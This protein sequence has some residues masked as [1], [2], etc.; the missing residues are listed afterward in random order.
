MHRLPPA[1]LL[2]LL[3][4]PALASLC[5][6]LSG[7]AVADSEA[8]AVVRQRLFVNDGDFEASLAIGATPVT[9]LTR[10]LALDGT[11]G[12]NVAETWSIQVRGTY[13]FSWHTRTADDASAAVTSSDPTVRFRQVDD[14]ED[15]WTLRWSAL[16]VGRWMPI[17][18]KVSLFSALPVHFGLY[19]AAGVGVGGLERDSLVIAD[20]HETTLRP[21]FF[22]ALGL[23]LYLTSLVSLNLEV[24]DRFFADSYRVEIDRL[25]EGDTGQD[26]ASP[27]LTHLVLVTLGVTFSF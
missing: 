22:G 23:R 18:G 2:A 24:G 27:G 7:T 6:L 19:L 9:F 14:Y 17:Y 25:S 10:H 15:L 13:A 4:V 3:F 1:P 26:A 21:L 5:P 8:P 11:L 16:A 12:W 20:L